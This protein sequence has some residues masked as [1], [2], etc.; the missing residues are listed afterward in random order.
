MK[1]GMAETLIGFF[2]LIVTIIFLIFALQ[3]ID[4]G[5]DNVI[6]LKARFYKVGNLNIGNEVKISGVKVGVVTDRSLDKQSYEALIT[7]SVDA[8]IRIPA[9]TSLFISGEG[10]LGGAYLRLSP[11]ISDQNLREGDEI[12]K[13]W[14]YE[15]LEDSVSKIIF[16]TTDK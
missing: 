2:V 10:L 8:D 6:N 4:K 5:N 16:M 7:F 11:G 13:T 12:L 9:D 1:R 14:D 3:F 15:S